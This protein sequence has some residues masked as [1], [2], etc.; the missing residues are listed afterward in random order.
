MQRP[1]VQFGLAPME[2]VTDFPARIWFCQT[3]R[4]DFLWTPFLRVTDTFPG[5]T[6]PPLYCPEL[7][8]GGPVRVIPQLMATNAGDFVRAAELIL[9]EHGAKSTASDP[10]W[11]DLN[12]GCPSPVVVGGRAGS[13]LLQ[14]LDAMGR[15]LD[16]AVTRLGAGRFSVKIRTGFASSDE[17]PAILAMLANRR[18]AQVAVHGRTRPERYLGHA[19]RDLIQLA[20]EN[21]AGI[22][23]VGSGDICDLGTAHV[24]TVAAPDV[25]AWIIGR[26]ALRNPWIFDELR[27]GKSVTIPVQVITAAV[28]S[29]AWLHELYWNDGPQLLRLWNDGAFEDCAGIDPDR[30]HRLLE[31]I[32]VPGGAPGRRACAR[33]KMI[34]NYFRS[35]LP[36]GM[37]AGEIL[38]A[39]RLED[40]VGAIEDL[41][42]SLQLTEFN[43]IY[44]STWDWVYNGAGRLG[45]PSLGAGGST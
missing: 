24:A 1:S 2:G 8:G 33:T 21:L 43:L 5:K 45:A 35:S 12:C 16:D 42:R 34:W 38:R 23:V 20:A 29:F 3:A 32:S 36:Q 9:S 18:L 6:I 40:L 41:A 17:F 39:T 28:Q 30:W 37:R 10:F 7:K 19:R 26:G 13:A 31:R 4:P 27:T 15:I 11:V 14:D 25:H 44:D 22:P